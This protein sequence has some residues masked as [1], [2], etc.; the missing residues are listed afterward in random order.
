MHD[1]INFFFLEYIRDQIRGADIALNKLEVGKLVD[2]TKISKARAVVEL[3]VHN[4]VVVRI[5]L[6]QQDGDV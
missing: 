6:T 1:C 4:D 3:V 2:I 5:L